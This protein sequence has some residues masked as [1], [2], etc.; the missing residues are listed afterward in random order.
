MSATDAGIPQN[1][2]VGFGDSISLGFKNYFQFEG[3]SSR[4][5]YWYFSLFLLIVSIA[6]AFFDALFIPGN[7]LSPLSSLFSLATLIPSISIS[8]RRLHDI[9]RSGWWNLLAFTII[10][11]IPLIYWVLQPG[12]RAK[13]G[14]GPDEEAGRA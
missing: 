12:N 3:R 7:E 14:F 1:R 5:S 11:I 2:I 8:V 13:N 9:G 6:T 4:G 10:G